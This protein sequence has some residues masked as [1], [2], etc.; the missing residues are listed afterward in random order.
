MPYYAGCY[1]GNHILNIRTKVFLKRLILAAVGVALV[2]FAV[3]SN[4][5]KSNRDMRLAYSFSGLLIWI[6][7][8]LILE[9]L[10]KLTISLRG[11]SLKH[12]KKN[13]I[14]RKLYFSAGVINLLAGL[15]GML[16]LFIQFDLSFFG[17]IASIAF[18][19]FIIGSFVVKRRMQKIEDNAVQSI[20]CERLRPKDTLIK[21]T[22]SAGFFERARTR[23]RR[24]KSLW[25]LLLIPLVIGF[26]ALVGWTLATVLLS[27]QRKLMPEDIIFSSFT[28]IAGLLM[29]VPIIFPSFAVGMMI[30]NL[31]IWCI[32]PARAALDKEAEGVKHASFRE[33]MRDLSK[34]SLILL[35]TMIPI[36]LIG[37]FN[38]FYLTA[39]GIYF[40][41]LFSIRTTHYAWDD[42]REITIRCY[43][44]RE[45]V[46]IKYIMLMKDGRNI[47]L[48]GGLQFRN[49][50]IDS[51]DKIQPFIN[52]QKDIKY[53]YEIEQKAADNLRQWDKKISDKVLNI[54]SGDQGSQ[55]ND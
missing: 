27:I 40:N 21:E 26:V 34:I 37:T 22:F 15:A 28:N 32:P 10:W 13:E 29:F 50:F 48:F 23:A 8:K 49:R 41:P 42:I 30:A 53:K 45:H 16:C 54:L 12:S 43:T 4:Y 25:N 55:Q 9:Y 52:A 35:L 51:Y 44:D 33:A 24:R 11:L 17:L 20:D 38:Y 1:T 18:S 19:Y 47:D 7:I 3:K 14:S 6:G 31:I 36:S 39:D 46:K 2:I 5:L